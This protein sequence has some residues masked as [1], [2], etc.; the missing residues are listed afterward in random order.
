[1]RDSLR[2]KLKLAGFVTISIFFGALL[3]ATIFYVG[4]ATYV[5]LACVSKIVFISCQTFHSRM[6][7]DGAFNL[8]NTMLVT[9]GGGLLFFIVALP[10][11]VLMTLPIAL[12]MSNGPESDAGRGWLFY[13]SMGML[14]GGGPWI[15]V[16]ALTFD[17]TQTISQNFGNSIF[18]LGRVVI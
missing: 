6:L 18:A 16:T 1:M 9:L 15:I 3:S 2:Y 13:I 12:G 5:Q 14:I 17:P 10:Q 8:N 7:A 4:Q 11:L